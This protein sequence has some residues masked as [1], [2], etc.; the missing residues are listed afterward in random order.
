MNEGNKQGHAWKSDDDEYVDNVKISV[1]RFMFL[2]LILL[3][4]WREFWRKTE[5]IDICP[6]NFNS[7]Q[8]N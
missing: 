2:F 8:N 4:F 6:P 1:F 7:K 3:S 5:N